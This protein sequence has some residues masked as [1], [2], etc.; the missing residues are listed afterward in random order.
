M[1]PHGL[2]TRT[3]DLPR[4]AARVRARAPIQRLSLDVSEAC[5]ALGVSWDTFTEHVAPAI[6]IVRLGRRKLIA[7][8]ELERFLDEHGERLGV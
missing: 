8:A 6:R 2:P 5:L 1:T 3:R 7:V 4:D